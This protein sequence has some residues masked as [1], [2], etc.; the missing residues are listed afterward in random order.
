[1]ANTI[2]FLAMSIS[3]RRTAAPD[4]IQR[5][6]GRLAYDVLGTGPLVVCLSGMGDIRATFRFLAPPVAEAGYRVA[7][8]ELRGHGDSDTTFSRYDDEAAAEDLVALVE[9]LGGPALLVGHSMSAAACVIAAARRPDLVSGLVLLGPFAREPK[10][11]PVMK[12]LFRLA[13]LQPWAKVVWNA[14]LPSLYAGR[15]PQDFAEHRAAMMAALD[16]PGRLRAFTRTTHT[17]HA[18]AEAALA[19]VE[20]PA[21]V[22]MGELDPDFPD[23]EAEASWLAD[24]LGAERLMVPEA[25]HYVHSQRP[26]LVVPAVVAFAGRRA[27]RG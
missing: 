26:D 8:M 7:V 2:S 24:A 5:P 9:E 21:L 23:P 15:K 12:G 11:N 10:I 17:S 25:G 20:A 13:M 4:F 18:P 14:Y 1:M 19:N 6:E 22:V 3:E 16:R 27:S